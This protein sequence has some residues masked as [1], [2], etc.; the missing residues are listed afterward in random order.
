MI[1]RG[2]LLRDQV[3]NEIVE[4]ILDGRLPALS[5]INEST[6]SADL[7]VSRTPLREALL[8]LEQD[9][10]V[11]AQPGRGFRIAPLS[12]KE[13][14]EIYPIVGVLEGLAVRSSEQLPDVAAMAAINEQIPDRQDDPDRWQ[15]LDDEFHRLLVAKTDNTRLLETL[16]TF[17]RIM[18]RYEIAYMRDISADVAPP[19]TAAS[20]VAEHRVI[21]EALERGDR[22]AASAAIDENWRA[23]MERLL[24]I[25]EATGRGEE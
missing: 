11:E 10:F 2:D 9:A 14:R 5:R 19:R 16:A 8:S 21:L 25:L 4:R 13:V 7:G 20:S 17:K 6:L 1:V 18:K 24:E 12:R 22:A 23:G 3:K 15:E